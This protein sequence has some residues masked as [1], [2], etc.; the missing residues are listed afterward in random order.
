M[1]ST[2]LIF[3]IALL[4]SLV[5]SPTLMA[6]RPNVQWQRTFGGPEDDF[7]F[8]VE[9]TRDGGYILVGEKWYQ[10]EEGQCSGVYLIKTN[11]L[12]YQQWYTIPGGTA[13]ERYNRG[14][15]VRQTA[16]GGF[17]IGGT[18]INGCPPLYMWIGKTDSLGQAQWT[19]YLS[20]GAEAECVQ[21]T[22]DGGYVLAGYTQ[23]YD[24]YLVKI[25]SYGDTVWTRTYDST[26]EAAYV[27]PC[28]DAG[29]IIVGGSYNGNLLILK[30]D[31]LSNEEWR[32]QY[33]GGF[34]RCVKMTPDSGYV[35]IGSTDRYGAGGFDLW[36]LKLDQNG[37]SLWT[38]TYGGNYDDFGH[39]V[40]I[41]A[42]GGYIITG[43]MT[44]D[45]QGDLQA[46]L[47]KTNSLGDSLWTLAVGGS[48]ED[49][50]FCGHQTADSGF[51][52]AGYTSSFGAGQKNVYLVKTTAELPNG[53]SPTPCLTLLNNPYLNPSYPNPFNSVTIIRF[54]II[55]PCPVSL[56]I[57]NLLGQQVNTLIDQSAVQGSYSIPWNATNLP[58]GIYFCRLQAG[59]FVQ[60]RKLVLL[61]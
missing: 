49:V 48:Y 38:H 18:V 17:I 57:Y 35:V 29:Y 26:D 25:N 31:S 61:K 4:F 36:L 41:T 51:V 44:L 50:A 33:S 56:Q 15:C 42:D 60:T 28:T 58:S 3:I 30:T 59:N 5:V 23:L 53:V 19:N 14:R 37:D 32:Q 7:A 46:Y 40:E 47:V 43:Y 39:T 55:T 2:A 27:E 10:S 11:A 34:G 54:D 20:A 13:L 1:K 6:Q 12:G 21:L 8:W 22:G 16:D 52:M 9:Q 24:F 45:E